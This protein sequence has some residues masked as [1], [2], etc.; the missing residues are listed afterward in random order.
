MFYCLKLTKT[1][2]LFIHNT[3]QSLESE[4]KLFKNMITDETIIWVSDKGIL[5]IWEE[6]LKMLEN[7]KNEIM[8]TNELKWIFPN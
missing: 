1:G 4:L 8:N 6:Y 2:S 3:P 7:K 5:T